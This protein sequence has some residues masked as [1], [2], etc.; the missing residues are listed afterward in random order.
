MIDK[1]ENIISRGANAIL[2]RNGRRVVEFCVT[3]RYRGGGSE[4]WQN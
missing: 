2:L 1:G 4:R 3:E